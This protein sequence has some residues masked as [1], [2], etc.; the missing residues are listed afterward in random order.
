MLK[1]GNCYLCLWDG[2]YGNLYHVEKMCRARKD[3]FI[4]EKMQGMN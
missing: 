2:I 1:S 4:L 3:G